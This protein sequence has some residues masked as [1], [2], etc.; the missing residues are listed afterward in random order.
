MR[1]AENCSIVYAYIIRSYSHSLCILASAGALNQRPAVLTTCTR[2]HSTRCEYSR[3]VCK[4]RL[5]RQMPRQFG[6]EFGCRGRAVRGCRRICHL[7]RLSR[8]CPVPLRFP[9]SSPTV[10]LWKFTQF[11]YICF[12][13]IERFGRFPFL[14]SKNKGIVEISIGEL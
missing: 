3:R 14:Q 9:Y 5:L 4:R 12:S 8:V 11:P 7:R 10:P 13:E 6:I 2:I 1:L